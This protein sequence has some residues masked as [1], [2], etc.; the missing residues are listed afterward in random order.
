M[1]LGSLNNALSEDSTHAS[2]RAWSSGGAGKSAQVG[3]NVPA[4]MVRTTDASKSMRMSEYE[5]R[6][7]VACR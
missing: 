1:E 5:S 3:G 7:R 2:P 6:I 4:P